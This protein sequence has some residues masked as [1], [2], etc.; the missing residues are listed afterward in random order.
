MLTIAGHDLLL[1]SG[2]LL[3]IGR[4]VGDTYVGIEDPKAIIQRL[5]ECGTRVD[6][7]TF[8]QLLPDISTTSTPARRHACTART[9]SIATAPS[10][11]NS[12]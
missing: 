4:I 6:L 1:D 11:Q 12:P 10:G 9:P 3:R 7:F 5:K 8:T 2:R